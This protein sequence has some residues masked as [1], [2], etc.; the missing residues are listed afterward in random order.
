V[1][2]TAPNEPGEEGEEV[3]REEGFY[4]CEE[5]LRRFP[6]R[7]VPRGGNYDMMGV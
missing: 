5:A 6:K 4:D 7:H 3:L 2:K 1:G